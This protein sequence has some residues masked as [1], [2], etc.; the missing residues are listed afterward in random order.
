M[1]DNKFRAGQKS[2]WSWILGFVILAGFVWFMLT[3]VYMPNGNLGKVLP[4][5]STYSQIRYQAPADTANEVKD[6]V[7]YVK[8]TTLDLSP[9]KYTEEGLIKLQS[10]L[11]YIADRDSANYLDDEKIDSLDRTIVKIDTSSSNYLRQVK[12]AFSAAVRAIESI[13]NSGKTAKGSAA[14]LRQIELNI[15]TSKSLDSQLIKIKE[16]FTEAGSA[17]QNAKL[18]YAYSLNKKSY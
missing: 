5:D 7:A 16:F 1:S 18:S 12:P 17:L 14:E 10:A 11:S 15:D 6:F 13:Q 4:G 9:K 2:P 3:Y 8:D